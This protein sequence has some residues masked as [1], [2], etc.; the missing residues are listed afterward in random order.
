MEHLPITAHYNDVIVSTIAP[1]ITSASI[2]YSTVCSG[3]NQRKHQFS[4]SLAFV[5]GIRLTKGQ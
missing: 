1:E 5:R 4:A 2:I 3:T